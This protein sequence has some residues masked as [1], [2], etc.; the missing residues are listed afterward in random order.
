ME[1]TE[2]SVCQL[3]EPGEDSTV[4]LDLADEPLAF[5]FPSDVQVRLA[6]KELKHL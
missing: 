2:V 5:G 4:V 3:V 1:E 6:P